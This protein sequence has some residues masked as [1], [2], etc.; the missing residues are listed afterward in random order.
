MASMPDSGVKG[1]QFKSTC[2]CQLFFA[3]ADFEIILKKKSQH[4]Q[5][6]LNR[7]P[8]TP[9]PGMLTTQPPGLGHSGGDFERL[10]I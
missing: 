8:F 1:L 10:S 5:V 7:R 2:R 9:V 4:L 6:D 3:F